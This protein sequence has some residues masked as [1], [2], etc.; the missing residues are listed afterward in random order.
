[1][2]RCYSLNQLTNVVCEDIRNEEVVVTAQLHSGMFTVGVLLI[3]LTIYYIKLKSHLSVHPSASRN[4]LS[5]FC[6]DRL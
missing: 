6:M 2:V 3:T 1:M 4:N 5:G